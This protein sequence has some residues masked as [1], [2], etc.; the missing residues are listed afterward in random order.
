[1]NTHMLNDYRND[2]RAGSI[3]FLSY[4]GLLEPL[5]ASQVLPYVRGLSHLGHKIAILS[6]E[7]SEYSTEERIRLSDDLSSENI[8]WRLCRYHKR[9]SMA[10]TL[11][12]VI[13]GIRHSIGMIRRHNI[14][15]V[16][17]RGHVP[18]LIAEI[19][20]KLTGI[21]YLFDHRGIMADEFADAGIWRRGGILYRMTDFCESWFI[22]HAVAVVVLTHAL[23]NE[24]VDQ[25]RRLAVIPCA[26]DIQRFQPAEQADSR[27]FD[28]V[29][30]GSW[31]G[32]YLSDTMLRFFEAYRRIRKHASMLVVTRS[33]T[34]SANER[35]SVTFRH[36]R[37][38]EMPFIL[39]TARA[40][41][42]LRR[43]GRAQMAASPV[44]VGEYLA[45]GLPFVSTAGVGDIDS[46]IMSRRVGVLLHDLDDTALNRAAHELIQ[47][48]D[49]PDTAVN[50][51]RVAEEHFALPLAI[52][53]YDG[54]YREINGG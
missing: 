46:L 25:V 7:K 32:L 49:S 22:R 23:A 6:F 16:H 30:A 11:Y 34:D 39:R 3:L 14:T 37:S 35:Q 26:V 40:G 5:G 41:L 47:L 27:P 48:T 52:A 18:A 54:L 13:M 43:P 10:A 36:A 51:R 38:D 9:P 15:L 8:A 20:K 53:R 4:T 50:C 17:A 33:P 2:S 29:Y 12:D 31:T 42:S 45:S 24:L 44:K 28:L 1:M 21:P 19:L